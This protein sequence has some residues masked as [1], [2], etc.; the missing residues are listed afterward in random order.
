MAVSFFSTRWNNTL[1]MA[2]GIMALL[3]LI[4]ALIAGFSVASFTALV[5]IGGVT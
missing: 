4:A 3:S 5:V 1:S 2:L